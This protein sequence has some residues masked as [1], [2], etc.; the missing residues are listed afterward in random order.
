MKMVSK[1]KGEESLP[2]HA[3]AHNVTDAMN[4]TY[5]EFEKYEDL[6]QKILIV[7]FT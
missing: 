7:P 2:E 5:V 6:P 3:K 4:A 1:V